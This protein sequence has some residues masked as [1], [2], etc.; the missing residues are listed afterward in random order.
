MCANSDVNIV[1]K[2][3]GDWVDLAPSLSL[4]SQKQFN[5]LQYLS[6]SHL[7]PSVDKIYSVFACRQ[8]SY[9]HEA[10]HELNLL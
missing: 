6:V 3:G 10:Y 9:E 4:A 8:R 2:P 1:N 7:F 5:L